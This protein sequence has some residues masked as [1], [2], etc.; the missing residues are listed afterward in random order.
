[1]LIVRDAQWR[2]F[3][4]GAET[5]FGTRVRAHVERYFPARCA[6]LGPDEV[7]AAIAHGQARAAAWDIV[8]ERDVCRYIDLTFAFGWNLDDPEV[9]PW[10][11]RILRDASKRGPARLDAL[12][13][14]ATRRAYEAPGIQ[15]RGGAR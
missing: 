4:P 3:A 15:P 8:S 10:A 2:A 1:M 9:Y 7:E 11:A 6:A 12:Y 13:D 5:R 14:A